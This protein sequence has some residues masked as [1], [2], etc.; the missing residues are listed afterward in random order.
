MKLKQPVRRLELETGDGFQI[1]S[2]EDFK[3]FVSQTVDRCFVVNIKDTEEEDV[4]GL[5]QVFDGQVSMLNQNQSLNRTESVASTTDS[6][7][8]QQ[9]YFEQLRFSFMYEWHALKY[10]FL[11]ILM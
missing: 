10:Y 4:G 2:D 6:N 11:S 9:V 3:V 1:S 5:N 7:N 8:N